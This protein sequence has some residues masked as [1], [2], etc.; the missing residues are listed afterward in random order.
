MEKETT[1]QEKLNGEFS[2]ALVIARA[3]YED[4]IETISELTGKSKD[5]VQKRIGEKIKIQS[6]RLT[7]DMKNFIGT[8]PTD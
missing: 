2:I 8:L 7:G 6:E 1:L 4:Y 3:L 5:E